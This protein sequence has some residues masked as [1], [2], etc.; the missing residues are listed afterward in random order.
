MA[1]NQL[2]LCSSNTE[3]TIFFY[4]L[5]DSSFSWQQL[6]SFKIISQVHVFLTSLLAHY[7]W[8]FIFS[9]SSRQQHWDPKIHQDDLSGCYFSCSAIK[10]PYFIS[11]FVVNYCH[12]KSFTDIINKTSHWEIEI[13]YEDILFIQ[14]QLGK[15]ENI[16]CGFYQ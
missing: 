7:D 15:Q 11:L 6:P 1:F 10:G 12:W 4:L 16:E 8:Y 5:T 3:S 9:T 2:A 13:K 14:G